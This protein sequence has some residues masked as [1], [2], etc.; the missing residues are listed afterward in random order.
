MPKLTGGREERIKKRTITTSCNSLD[1]SNS[2]PDPEADRRASAA[3]TD[4]GGGGRSRYAIIGGGFAGL[5]TCWNL[6]KANAKGPGG[7]EVDVY[8]AFGVGQGGASAAASGLLHPLNTRGNV[9]WKGLEALAESLELMR[10]VEQQCRKEKEKEEEEEE[11][12]T[13]KSF[14]K[15]TGVFRF[16]KD[17]KQ[18]ERYKRIKEQ[19]GDQLQMQVSE[20]TQEDSEQEDHENDHENAQSD[21]SGFMFTPLGFV[22]DSPSYLKRL[23][24]AC[25]HLARSGNS[26]VSTIK[27]TVDSLQSLE[28]RNYSAILICAGAAY[29]TIREVKDQF[30]LKLSETYAVELTRRHSSDSDNDSDR[31]GDRDMSEQQ[32]EVLLDGGVVGSHSLLGRL[33][34]VQPEEGKVVLGAVHSETSPSAEAALACHH[35]DQDCN[36]PTT[37]DDD[38]NEKKDDEGVPV[39]FMA[40]LALEKGQR[41]YPHFPFKKYELSRVHSGV[42]ALPP[43][44]NCGRL[45]LMGL[46]ELNKEKDREDKPK[47][48]TPCWIFL[49]LGA[50]GLLYHAM[51]A[52]ELARA[53]CHNDEALLPDE[54]LRWK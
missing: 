46:V 29:S 47:P 54:V 49:G 50:R 45:P 30:P 37:E 48:K 33:Y 15:Q 26:K 9:G 16:A 39:S 8:D 17:S 5:A 6:L 53:V 14:L 1:R 22:V 40:K 42:R 20:T 38:D 25:G 27:H 19:W 36:Y 11:S 23:E 52:K 24:E 10:E 7:V 4:P 13:T 35:H 21:K 34:L 32:R 3:T 18:L 43:K 28:H 12:Q 41:E 44:S 2:P 31:V 51:L